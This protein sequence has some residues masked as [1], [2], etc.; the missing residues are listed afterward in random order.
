MVQ[1]FH[2]EQKIKPDPTKCIAYGQT[3]DEAEE[4]ARLH[5]IGGDTKDRRRVTQAP[6]NEY[7]IRHSRL[8]GGFVV[9]LIEPR[10]QTPHTFYQVPGPDDD[11][12]A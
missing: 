10:K 6:P 2:R 8:S 1:I 11:G 12:A 5:G 4:I 7:G 9:G 3:R